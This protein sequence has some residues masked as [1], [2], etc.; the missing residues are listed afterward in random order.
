MARTAGKTAKTRRAKRALA[1][2]L[3][4]SL[5]RHLAKARAS[6]PRRCQRPVRVSSMA[7]GSVGALATGALSLGAGALGALAIGRLAI[8]RG[9]VGSLRVEEL[10][11]GK[12]RVD[13]LTVISRTAGP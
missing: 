6:R 8:K 1:L 11:V 5:V 4:R 7:A 13:E 10:Q 2:A 3:T 12:L 9:S